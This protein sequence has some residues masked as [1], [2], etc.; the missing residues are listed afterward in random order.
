MVIPEAFNNLRDE[1]IWVAWDNENGKKTPKSPYGG[2]AKS[3][4]P[5]TWGTYGQASKL[6][7]KNNYSG[8]GIMLCDGYIGIDLDGAIEDGELSQWAEDIVDRFDSYTEISPSGTGVH[9]IANADINEVGLIGR[10]NHSAGVE[11]YNY[12]RYFTVTGKQIAGSGLVDI[13]EKVKPFID[14]YFSGKSPDEIVCQRIGAIAKGCN[15]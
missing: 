12:G 13:T 9:I 1:P 3:N 2:N 11:I 14:E 5:T 8:V 4:D 10:A 15:R 6:A 7:K